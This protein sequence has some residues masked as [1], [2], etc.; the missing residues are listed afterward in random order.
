MKK[1][2]ISHKT[3]IFTVLFLISLW[4]VY[5]IKD[6]ILIFFVSV[7]LMATLNPLVTRLVRLRLPRG[8]AILL[9]YILMLTL[10]VGSVILL[11]PPLVDQTANFAQN[12]PGY[13]SNNGIFKF[14]SDQVFK[15]LISQLGSIPS[16]IL[17][18]GL[19][20]FSNIIA[21][22]SIL[23]FAFY[24]LIAREKLDE[25]A[26]SLF[27]EYKKKMFV[28]SFILLETKLGGWARAELSLMLIIGFASF[29]GLVI[30]GI[31]YALPLALLS[32]IFEAVPNLGPVVSMI[33]AAI[34]AFGISPIMGFAVIAL[35]FLLHQSENYFLVP[36]IMEKSVGVNPVVTLLS[37]AIGFKLAGIVGAVIAVPVFI[38]IQTIMML[39][40]SRKE[41]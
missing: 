41:E 29:L 23:M 31:P 11:I 24:L 19:S 15:D 21:V 28:D 26:S 3:I 25:F 33:P 8:I 37:L 20:L 17:K 32:G 30:L 13:L 1:V 16:Q 6:I 4:F 9:V 14:V 38:T 5:Y 12:L 35:Y 36:K 18:V 7:L 10:L 2:E 34:I 40:F 22:I 39:Q 27:G